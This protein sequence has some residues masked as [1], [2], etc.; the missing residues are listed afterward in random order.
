MPVQR[1]NLAN[2]GFT[3]K[4][5]ANIVEQE[6]R[7]AERLRDLIAK[8]DESIKALGWTLWDWIWARLACAH[9]RDAN[10]NLV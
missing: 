5:P 1:E 10:S 7:K 9:I 6:R 2:A 3:S 8:I 4:A